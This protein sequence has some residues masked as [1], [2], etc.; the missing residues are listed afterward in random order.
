M[1]TYS[2]NKNSPQESLYENLNVLQWFQGVVGNLP[3][4]FE[5]LEYVCETWH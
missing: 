3:F 1:L 5:A 2:C 4:I